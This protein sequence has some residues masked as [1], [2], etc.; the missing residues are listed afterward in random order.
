[1]KSFYQS[2][3][4]GIWV[5]SLFFGLASTA[6]AINCSAASA[7]WNRDYYA[8]PSGKT[9]I[10]SPFQCIEHTASS[11]YDKNSPTIIKSGT[12]PDLAECPPGQRCLRAQDCN[13]IGGICFSRSVTMANI[14]YP[15]GEPRSKYPEYTVNVPF[16]CPG[17]AS[18]S[19]F[20]PKVSSLA[21]EPIITPDTV[22]EPATP[23]DPQPIRPF[24]NCCREIVPKDGNSY[25][26]GK[27]GLNHFI[28][29]GI[30]IY[31]CI[32]CMVAA[33][34]LLMFVIGSFYLM[35]S[36][37]SKPSVDK[38][39]AIIKNAIIG[40]IIV[41]ASILIVNYS[42]KALGGSFL[43]AQKLEINANV[44]PKVTSVAGSPA[45]VVAVPAP[46]PPPPPASSGSI[47]FENCS[48]QQKQS[49]Y[50]ALTLAKGQMVSD[51]GAVDAYLEA[52]FSKVKCGGNLGLVVA[53][54]PYTVNVTQ[55]KLI[56]PN[57]VTV[58]NEFFAANELMNLSTLIHEAIHHYDCVKQNFMDDRLVDSDCQV[59][60]HAYSVQADYL[61]SIGELIEAK[62]KRCDWWDNTVY[63]DDKGNKC[64]A[65]D[66]KC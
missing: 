8:D 10:S 19:C 24:T 33:L 59:E 38:G 26:E 52:S 50:K 17:D 22:S 42:V 57:A 3:L 36:A 7:K 14:K 41:F 40:A 5:F 12:G 31:E 47:S 35:T 6:S 9:F 20:V 37:G 65:T 39:I 18:I 13:D 34:M 55:K 1:M 61:E 43:D 32:L 30:N 4:L 11:I 23:E 44:G 25:S 58:Y 46:P 66:P 54:Y 56:C 64:K 45:P 21:V 63:T 15:D 62:R 53:E 51:L 27:Y 2:I 16:R 49:F 28:Q 29:V 60:Q 48:E